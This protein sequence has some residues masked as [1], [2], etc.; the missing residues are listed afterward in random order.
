MGRYAFGRKITNIDFIN[1]TQAL[2]TSNDSR[3]RLVNISDGKMIQKYKGHTNNEFMI[4]CFSEDSHDLIISSSEDGF[5]YVWPKFNK[6]TNHKK[7]YHYEFFRP[8]EKDTPTCSLFMSDRSVSN[9]FKKLC[10][11]SNQLVV[12]SIV[13][14]AS[15]G[16]RVQV[17]LNMEEVK[18]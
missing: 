16:G 2:I 5:V 1:R 17:L 11:A 7:N 8:F 4:R 10:L 9:Y 13:L 6:E 14:N 12:Y 15:V 18:I 3:I